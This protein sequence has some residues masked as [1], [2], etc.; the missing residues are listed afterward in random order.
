MNAHHAT[1]IALYDADMGWQIPG[2]DAQSVLARDPT[3]ST[4]KVASFGHR[5]SDENAAL[6][7]GR[8]VISTR[9]RLSAFVGGA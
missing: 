6:V 2:D 4:F 5:Y 9:Y 8:L 3:D 1:A 7:E